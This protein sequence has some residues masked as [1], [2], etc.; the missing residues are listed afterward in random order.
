MYL[1]RL[2][3]RFTLYASHTRRTAT[4]LRRHPLPSILLLLLLPLSF[5]KPHGAVSPFALFSSH[6]F[7]WGYYC[8]RVKKRGKQ[9]GLLINGCPPREGERAPQQQR[10]QQREREVRHRSTTKMPPSSREEKLGVRGRNTQNTKRKKER[11]R[12]PRPISS[13][14]WGVEAP[15]FPYARPYAGSTSQRSLYNEQRTAEW[16]TLCLNSQRS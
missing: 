8:G 6:F 4:R 2:F 13:R 1:V 3:A 15:R 10:R 9:R 12:A 7:F 16:S 11:E 5:W 14:V